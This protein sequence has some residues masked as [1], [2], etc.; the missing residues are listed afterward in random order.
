M[1]PTSS[2]DSFKDYKDL[3]NAR[4]EALLKALQAAAEA[5]EAEEVTY[6]DSIDQA[7]AIADRA[8]AAKMKNRD[9]EQLLQIE[10][11]LRRIEQGIFGECERCA[12]PIT[13]ARMKAFPLTTLCIDCKAE[14]ES[15]EHRFPGRV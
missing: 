7:S 13:E 2:K 12:E 8:L 4:R 10:G 9:R 3:L 15:E 5:S 6:A 11:A 14:L 1:A